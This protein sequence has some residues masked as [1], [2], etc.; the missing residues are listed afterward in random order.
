MK[1]RQVLKFASMPLVM[2]VN[3]INRAQVVMDGTMV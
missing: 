2:P 1:R 3:V